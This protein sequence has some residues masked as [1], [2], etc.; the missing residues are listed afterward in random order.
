MRAVETGKSLIMA[1]RCSIM[2]GASDYFSM[3][4]TKAWLKTWYA[5]C[6]VI[7]PLIF[8]STLAKANHG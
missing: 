1:V 5:R 3:V 4:S 8:L 6:V 2:G 7:R